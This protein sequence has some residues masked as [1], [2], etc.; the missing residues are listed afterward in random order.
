MLCIRVPRRDV[1]LTGVKKQNYRA[2]GRV[3]SRH[4]NPRSFL[5]ITDDMRLQRVET[6]PPRTG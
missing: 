2:R 3:R 4:N 1:L 6:H 5:S